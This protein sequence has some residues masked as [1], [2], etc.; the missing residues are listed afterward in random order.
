MLAVNTCRDVALFNVAS[1]V[2]PVVTVLQGSIGFV[3]TEVAE[4]I[5][6]KTKQVL[7]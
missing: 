1:H 7:L 4:G 6:S 3:S 2:W 5:M